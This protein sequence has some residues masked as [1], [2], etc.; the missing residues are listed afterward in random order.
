VNLTDL[1]DFT[2]EL[3]DTLGGGGLS[4]INVGEDTDVSVQG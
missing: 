2:G 1:V 4:S 3:E